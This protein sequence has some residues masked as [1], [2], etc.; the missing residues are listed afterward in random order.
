MMTELRA[1]ANSFLSAKPSEQAISSITPK[2][3][4]LNKEVSTT[5]TQTGLFDDSL[6]PHAKL[7]QIAAINQR[8]QMAQMES[9]PYSMQIQRPQNLFNPFPYQFGTF[10]ISMSRPVPNFQMG[11]QCFPFP[12]V[13]PGSQMTQSRMDD[14]MLPQPI[15]L[16]L[17]SIKSSFSV[18]ENVVPKLVASLPSA[19]TSPPA[20]LKKKTRNL[21]NSEEEKDESLRVLPVKESTRKLV[22]GNAYKRRNVYKSV[23][24]H[25][26]SYVR[27]NRDDILSILK[28]IGYS[29]PEIEHAFFKVNYYNDEERQR[30]GK[31]R[32][33]NIVKNIV[34]KNTI[35][36]PIL[37]ETLFA[38]MK[39]WEDGKYGKVSK[40]NL[41]VY[42]EVCRKYYDET[43]RLL[44]KSSEG[45]THHL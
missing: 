38:M 44:G 13:W 16:P 25:M 23:V 45:K 14:K 21:E 24:R 33:Q 6:V 40:R 3:P 26:F 2:L 18:G 5:I 7:A 4:P 9:Y 41:T 15:R 19:F 37:R 28:N 36:V 32:S 22:S 34:A 42:K 1:T 17:S 43:V 10:P 11:G 29:I 31:K 30:G 12:G 8:M 35:Y 27:K 39:R 20:E